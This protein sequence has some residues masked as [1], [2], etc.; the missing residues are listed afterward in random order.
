MVIKGTLTMTP[1]STAGLYVQLDGQGE[2]SVGPLEG[3]EVT[4]AYA[5]GDRVAVGEML[6]GDYVVLGRLP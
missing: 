3:T 4:P 1:P 2:Y 5:V 6:G